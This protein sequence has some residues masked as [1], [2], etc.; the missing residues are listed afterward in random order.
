MDTQLQIEALAKRSRWSVDQIGRDFAVL[1]RY[2]FAV[3]FL[4]TGI[5]KLSSGEVFIESIRGYGLVPVAAVDVVAA[6]VIVSELGLGI[7]LASGHARREALWTA[8]AG[9]LGFGAI[10]AVAAWRGAAGDCGCFSGVAESSIGL[11]AIVRNAALAAVA[12]NAA[13]VDRPRAIFIN[14]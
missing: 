5:A 4:V 13:V 7:W 9:L 6:V 10:V 11:G 2:G 1:V 12:I 8:A 14:N 3:M